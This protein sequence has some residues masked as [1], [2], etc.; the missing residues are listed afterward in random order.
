MIHAIVGAIAMGCVVGGFV[1]GIIL[2]LEPL[3][4]RKRGR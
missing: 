4:K 2:L 1:V 3:T